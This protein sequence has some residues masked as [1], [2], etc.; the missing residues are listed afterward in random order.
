[1]KHAVVMAA[2]EGSRLRPLTET[3]PKPIL[4]IDG[5]AVI[6]TLL[7]DLAAAGIEDVV[8]VTGHLAEQ[9]EALVGDGAGFGLRA[10]F[11]RQ[12]GVLGSADAVRRGLAAGA[13]S[14]LLV[15]AADTVFADGDV[16]RF[17][18]AAAG[19]AGA[20]AVRRE[21]APDPPHRWGTRLEDGRVVEVLDRSRT[22][23]VS[24]APL[25]ALGTELV[26]YLDDLGGP[27]FEL[28]EAF[29]RA[30]DA[31]LEIRGVEIGKTRD[32]THP[33]D[34]VRENFPYLG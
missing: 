17:A 32:L 28:A 18:A 8:V 31:G 29:E 1:M 25:W 14:P 5:R 27:P 11:A 30:V 7:R 33:A 2:G 10:T 9:V 4:P 13:R 23:D 21:P 16:A 3:W 19:A 26:P 34:L 22:S 15:C 24:G 12:P 20:L 6:A